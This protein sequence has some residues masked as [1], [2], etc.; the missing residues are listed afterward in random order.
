MR[1][2]L[3]VI[4]TPDFKS[5]ILEFFK[6]FRWLIDSKPHY[7]VKQLRDSFVKRY[8][9]WNALT[10]PQ[11]YQQ[12]RVF[13]AKG[14]KLL[15]LPV[16]TQQRLDR[17]DRVRKFRAEFLKD[18]HNEKCTIMHEYKRYLLATEDDEGSSISYNTYSRLKKLLEAE[19]LDSIDDDTEVN[20]NDKP[21]DPPT[22]D[23]E[24]SVN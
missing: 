18:P 8:P 17:L 15:S 6:D 4:R 22:V 10:T 3:E 5:K 23:N 24:K 19:A 16:L 14:D 7:Y 11:V 2:P 20:E 9:E 12:L 21:A 1:L 13:Q